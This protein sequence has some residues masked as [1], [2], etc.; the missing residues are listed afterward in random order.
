MG[1][2][3]SAQPANEAVAAAATTKPRNAF[4]RVVL[5]LIRPPPQLLLPRVLPHVVAARPRPAAEPGVGTPMAART[6]RLPA[7][8]PSRR[9]APERADA[10]SPVQDADRVLRMAARPLP[11]L[12]R[13]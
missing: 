12:R 4:R 6:R 2:S 1:T 13:W 3:I 10:R 8:S 5:L 11:P 9:V 7:S